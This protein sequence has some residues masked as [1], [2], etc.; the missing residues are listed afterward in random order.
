[1]IQEMLYPCVIGVAS[2]RYAV[3]PSA[4]L[5]E[6][7]TAPV[8]VVERRIGDDIIRFQVFV[9][10]VQERTLVVPFYL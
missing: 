10:I 1:M 6:Q 7:I 3:F 5:A 4:I 2:G 9:G 8:A